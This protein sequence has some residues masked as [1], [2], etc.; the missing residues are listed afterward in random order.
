M[1]PSTL[2]FE[3]RLKPTL[4]EDEL[5][6]MEW[7]KDE[8]KGPEAMDRM[9]ALIR[10]WAEIQGRE[11]MESTTPTAGTRPKPHLRINL[12]AQGPAQRGAGAVQDAQGVDAAAQNTQHV[13]KP[14][15]ALQKW[16]W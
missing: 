14:G 16:L 4:H 10:K 7:P 13:T 3:G 8:D 2:L 9:E 15:N 6:H 12:A 5:L 11:Y 1:F